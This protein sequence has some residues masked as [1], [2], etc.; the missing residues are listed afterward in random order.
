M[1]AITLISGLVWGITF[2]YILVFIWLVLDRS[3]W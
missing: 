3:P 2:L 1:E